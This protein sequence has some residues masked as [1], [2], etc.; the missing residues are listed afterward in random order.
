[1]QPAARISDMHV[2]PMFDGPKPH[3]GG[4]IVKGCDSVLIGFMPAARNSDKAICV[5]RPDTISQGSSS[6]KIGDEDAAR[7][8][9]S[10]DHGGVIVSGC[11]TVLIG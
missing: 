8:G 6:V 3:I 1:M 4:P 9:D 5:G 2:C 10:T 11:F 7:M